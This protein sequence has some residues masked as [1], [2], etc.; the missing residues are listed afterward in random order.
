MR[1]MAILNL[2]MFQMRKEE[3][4]KNHKILVEYNRKVQ[5]LT[6][7]EA[8]AASIESKVLKHSSIASYNSA[9]GTR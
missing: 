1:A 5:N 6:L 8:S 3:A 2:K 9:T 4:M 7:V